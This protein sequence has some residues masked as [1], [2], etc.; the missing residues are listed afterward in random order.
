VSDAKADDRLSPPPLEQGDTRVI[1][2]LLAAGSRAVVV[3][4]RGISAPLLPARREFFYGAI[5]M[6]KQELWLAMAILT[7]CASG[8]QAQTVASHSGFNDP[9]EEG[10]TANGIESLGSPIDDGGTLAWNLNTG[11]A[12]QEL[13]YER[14]LTAEEIAFAKTNGYT[15]RA[16]LRIPTA[17]KLLGSDGMG[18]WAQLEDDWWLMRFSTDSS[19]NPTVHIHGGGGGNHQILGSGYHNYELV[20]DPASS[21]ADLY[22]DNIEVLSD[23]TPAENPGSIFRFGDG[24]G[25][26]TGAEINYALVE[27]EIPGLPSAE[28]FTWNAGGSGDWTNISNWLPN[29]TP[30]AKQETAILGDNITSAETV[31]INEAATVNRIEFNNS[32]PYVVAGFGTLTLE[33]DDESTDPSIA[34]AQG[35]HQLQARVELASDTVVDI[36]A[37]A[38]LDF[39]NRLSLN[40]NT[41]TK[42][43]DGVLTVNNALN[44]GDGLLIALGGSIVGGGTVGGSMENVSAILSPGSSISTASSSGDVTAAVPEP[45]SCLLVVLACLGCSAAGRRYR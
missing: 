2:N 45:T 10:F 26:F 39:I 43:G 23:L 18:F 16:N 34:V 36:A 30:D 9:T 17:G 31:F 29:G 24:D 28:V 11:T 21:S 33:A 41:L 22:V 8:A 42:T 1:E 44:S 15:L 4:A 7:L 5:E 27:M 38:S 19:A 25:S 13:L 35:A 14:P 40:G 12:G 37:D 20:Y 32:N 3:A 6:K